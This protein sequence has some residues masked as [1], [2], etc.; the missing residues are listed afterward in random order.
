M[1][2]ETTFP[3]IENCNP[4]MCISSKMLRCQRIISNVYRK[5]LQPFDITSSQLSILFI[6]TKME[7]VNQAKLSETLKLEKSTVSRNMKRLLERKLIK[8]EVAQVVSITHSGKIL[9][10]QIIPAWDKATA[11]ARTILKKEGEQAL[12]SLLHQL[13]R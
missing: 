8:K 7:N 4:Q 9:L 6:V 13:T 2:T 12:D 1:S 5:Y 10:E 3:N 11:E